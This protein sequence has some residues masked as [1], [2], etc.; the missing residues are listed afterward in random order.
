MRIIPRT[1]SVAALSAALALAAACG[2]GGESGGD[3][4]SNEPAADRS[5]LLVA[6][7]SQ[8]LGESVDRFE[9]SVESVEADFR[10]EIAMDG[11]AF[12]A[13][14]DFAFRSPDSMHMVMKMNGGGD[15]I[16]FGEFGEF[17][18]LLL[19]SEIYMNTGFTGWVTMSLDD[20][21]ADADSLKKL[22]EGHTPLDYQKLVD[23]IGGDVQN[24]GEI[25]IEGKTYTRLR[26]TT[27]FATL[28]ESVADSVG[29][30][31]FDPA[32]L[33]GDVSGP[34]TLDITVDPATLLPHKFEAKGQFEVEGQSADF[35]MLFTFFNYNGAV[36]IPAPP[37]NAQP[38][39]DAFGDSF[40]DPYAEQ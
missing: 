9:D 17:E 16:D 5:E 22:M 6:N 15:G 27:D 34:M 39:S 24:L 35:S 20:L 12:G 30:S 23:D 21:G 2:G 11:I 1:L 25:T 8:A 32:T 10:F 33:A 26:I 31:G 4:T 40:G 14:G 13:D 3:Q 37:A 38:F 18:V 7:P 29:D 36:N 19:G 28:L